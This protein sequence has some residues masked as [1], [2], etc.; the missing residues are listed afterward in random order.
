MRIVDKQPPPNFLAVNPAII[1]LKK[2]FIIPFLKI[3]LFITVPFQI[4][5]FEA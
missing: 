3:D 4:C 5:L 1:A 2:L